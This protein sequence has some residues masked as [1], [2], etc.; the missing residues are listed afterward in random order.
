MVQTGNSENNNP[1]DPIATQLDDIAAKLEAFE[2]MKEDIAALKEGERSRSISSRNGEGDSSWRGRQPQRAYN[3]IDFLIFSSGDPRG[4]LIKAKKYFKYYQIPDEEKV[5]IASMRLE[6][7]AL[8]LYSWLSHDQ[9]I[10]F[11]EELVQAFTRRFGSVEFQ[12]LD[13]FL[14]S[15][16]QTGSPDPKPTT[17]TPIPTSTQPKYTPRIPDTEKQNRLLKGECFICGD[18]YGPGH[19]CKTGTLKVLEAEEDMEEPRVTQFFNPDFDQEEMAEI[20][21]HA[22]LAKPHLTTMKVRAVRISGFHPGDLVFYIL[23]LKH[24]SFSLP[25]VIPLPITKSWEIYLKPN[26]VITHRWVYE[27]G[28]PVL[29]LLIVWCNRPVEEASWETYDLL[30][31]HFPEFCLEDKAF[32]RRETRSK[33]I[34]SSSLRSLR[35]SQ[36]HYK[37]GCGCTPATAKAAW[38]LLTDIVK[39]NKRSRTFVLK[40]E[41]PS[42]KHSTLSMEAYFQKIDSLVIILT[43]LGSIVNDEDVVYYAVEGLPE[44]YNQVYGY[45]HYQDT[46]PDLKK[47]RSLLI[48]EEMRLNSKADALLMDSS[49]PMDLMTESGNPR[50]SSSTPQV[51]PWKLCFHCCTVLD[52]NIQDRIYVYIKQA[53][54]HHHSRINIRKEERLG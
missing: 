4:W 32:Y 22:I 45:M 21:L 50:R 5:E 38:N 20:S 41:L 39:D 48:T 15:I 35:P 25:P 43:S 17:F 42:I 7:D 34:K 26:S 44:K 23:M 40:V 49:S 3:K 24:G 27:A 8:D 2:T 12:N 30:D 1:P 51:K 11:Y 16:K 14:C 33:L 10:M 13:E 47:V 53:L 19:R 37:K 9:T 36:T 46:F 54:C 18:K 29:E 6:R 28:Q 52:S 31:E